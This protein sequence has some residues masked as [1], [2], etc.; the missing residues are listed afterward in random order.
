MVERRE[1]TS[2]EGRGLGHSWAD[3]NVV[4]G[5]PEVD[6]IKRRPSFPFGD[7]PRGREINF[8]TEDTDE[9]YGSTIKPVFRAYRG[10]APIEGQVF[11]QP[12]RKGKIIQN[13][14]LIRPE[15]PDRST[16]D[17]TNADLQ[18]QQLGDLVASNFQALYPTPTITSP[19][20]GA[21]F[22]PGDSIT[23]VAPVSA[24][25]NIH[26]ATLEID[27][28][29]VDRRTIDRRDQDSTKDHTFRFIY[30]V[31]TDRALGPMSITVR[32]FNMNTANRG[33]IQD[34]A[35]GTDPRRTGL[36]TLDGRPGSKTAAADY[37][38]LLGETGLLRSPEGVVSI[39]VNI[40]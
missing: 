35:L 3:D 8:T 40:V 5:D 4:R 10:R 9:A 30:P 23:V 15:V 11:G 33:I 38:K 25:R 28:Q 17:T 19:A 37:Q 27:N 16:D 31:P 26:S 18:N 20:P 32:A 7:N 36:G 22:S 14:R 29:A 34:D 1:K 39:V 13:V 2:T 21:T 12:T 6:F 24:L